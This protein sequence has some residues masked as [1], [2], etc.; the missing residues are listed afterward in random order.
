[1]LLLSFKDLGNP[2]LGVK[3]S[4]GVIDVAAAQTAL[5]VGP[6]DLR[7]P[8][9]MEDLLADGRSGLDALAGLVESA[10]ALG[11]DQP[12][13]LAESELSLAPCVPNPGKIIC[14][15]LNYR[16]HAA[17]TGKAVPTTPLLFSKF[18]SA[19]AACSEP[20][21]LPAVAHEYDYEGEL[22]VVIGR[23]A[24]YVSE[25]DALSYV[26]GYCNANDVSARDLQNRTSQYLLGKTLDKFF[27]VGP[28]VVT[29]DEVGD[30]Q[31]LR[32]RCWLNDELRQDSN[33]SDM[34]FGV[35]QLVSYI[36]QYLSLEPGDVIA[37][38]TP[39]GVIM[40]RADKTWVKPG[41]RVTV[42]VEKLGRLTNSFVK[43]LAA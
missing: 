20:I 14:I 6:R 2:R 11:P 39:E 31:A 19:L 12:W 41:D 4:S 22:G 33:T 42:E 21:P 43:E 36:S 26:L 3:I 32:I 18:S 35:A 37:T 29:S 28:Y 34:I 10:A 15:G 25:E 40:G 1:M 7:A 17:E 27:P 38:G 30:P 24:R 9:T 5:G 13:L 16:R 8:E 23:R